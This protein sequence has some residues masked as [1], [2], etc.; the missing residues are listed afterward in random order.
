M[1]DQTAQIQNALRAVLDERARMPS[2]EHREHH[3]WVALQIAKQEARKAFWQAVMTK[4][5]PAALVTMAAA[6]GGWLWR[7]VSE[8]VAMR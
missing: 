5:M 4:A 6:F 1:P 8:H 2:E 3:E 7:W